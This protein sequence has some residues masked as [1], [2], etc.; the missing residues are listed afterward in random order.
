MQ[1]EEAHKRVD[2][3][4]DILSR[5]LPEGRL[6]GARVLDVGCGSGNGLIAALAMGA[7]SVVGID[8]DG[9]EFGEIHF[10][11]VAADFGVDPRHATLI[12]G[13]IF[14]MKFFDPGFDVV[15]MYDAIEHVPDPAA[16][17]RFC[18]EALAPGGVCLIVTCPLF[19]GAVGHHLWD[20]FPEATMPWA[21]LH[22]DFE[23]RI[24][25]AGVDQWSLQRY[26]EL[27]KVTHSQILQ[28]ISDAGMRVIADG[29][30][31]HPRF[32]EMLEANRHLID[33]TKVPS[34]ADLLMDYLAI[35]FGS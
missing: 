16:F 11:Q 24:A 35:S 34:E 4:K 17:I 7:K 25:A 13:D 10:A 6:Q 28:Y 23:D 1:I 21:H 15:V 19:Y 5:H 20:Y 33:M 8:R 27:N 12:A 18:A 14:T 9:E 30:I 26:R 22:P 29:S 2:W 32:P 3:A 31:A